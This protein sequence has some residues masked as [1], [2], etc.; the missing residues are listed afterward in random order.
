MN[1][2]V[3]GNAERVLGFALKNASRRPEFFFR[4]TLASSDD[5]ELRET[6]V[7]IP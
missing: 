7:L 3:L 6:A 1:G 5:A 2:A 4:K